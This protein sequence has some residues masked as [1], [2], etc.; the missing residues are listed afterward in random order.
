LLKTGQK[1]LVLQHRQELIRQNCQTFQKIAPQFTTSLMIAQEKSF[2]GNVVF[3]MVPTLARSLEDWPH[4]DFVVADEA[5]HSVANT[6][7]EA[8]HKVQETNPD[9]RILG[10]TAT[11]SR[12]DKVGLCTLFDNVA[13]QIFLGELV[14]SG[15]LVKPRTFVIKLGEEADQKLKDLYWNSRG[16]RWA[17]PS[18]NQMLTSA[19][20]ILNTDKY[21]EEVFRH[22]QEKAGDR[23][24]VVFCSTVDHAQDIQSTFNYHGIPTGH[25]NGQLHDRERLT[26]LQSF[27]EGELRVLNNVAVLTE[28]WD[29]PEVSCVILLRPSSYKSTMIQ[30]VGRGLRPFEGKEDCLILDFGLSSKV[31]GSLEQDVNL[32]SAGERIEQKDKEEEEEEKKTQDVGPARDLNHSL[33]MKEIDMLNQRPSAPLKKHFKNSF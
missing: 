20:E 15:H 13:D 4:F 33:E 18:E 22:W 2:D 32:S 14:E 30:M 23:K 24:T 5:H 29:C 1:A 7:T 19:S 28:G 10:F 8:V 12:G 17:N 16:H 26:T 31:Y 3:A 6:W 11:P 25:I 9:V 27:Q 21:N